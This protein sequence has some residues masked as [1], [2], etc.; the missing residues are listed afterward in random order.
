MGGTAKLKLLVADDDE[1]LQKAI[2]RF[3]EAADFE[4][5][6]EFDGSTVAAEALAWLPDII[7]LDIT[8]PG[9]DGRDV[10]TSLKLHPDTARIPVLMCSARSAQNDRLVG[11]KLGADDYVT[12]PY[13]PKLLL[14]RLRH[15]VEKARG[16]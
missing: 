15:M 14:V 16:L 11:L 5:R 2:K 7:L 12:K 6:Q 9:A 3:A 1:H 4:V 10:L 8:M 13:D